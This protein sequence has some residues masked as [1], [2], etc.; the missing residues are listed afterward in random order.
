MRTTPEVAKDLLV[1]SGQA[2]Q[3]QYRQ[4][5]SDIGLMMLGNE[6][7]Y[8]ENDPAAPAKLSMAQ[9]ILGKNPKAQSALKADPVFQQLF[10]N[11]IKNLQMSAT[12][13]QNAT[14]GRLGVSPAPLQAERAMPQGSQ[15]EAQGGLQ[16][17]PAE[18]AR[19]Q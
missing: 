6:A 17:G 8:T 12:Q 2:S 4:V 9:Q 1:D 3:L 15:E 18:D 14:I 11:Y 16:H 10:G 13:Q 5:Q 7:L 19:E